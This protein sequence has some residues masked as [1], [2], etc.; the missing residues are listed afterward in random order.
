MKQLLKNIAPLYALNAKI[1]ARA[2]KK[3]YQRTCTYYKSQTLHQGIKYSEDKV[4]K[5]VLK[6]LEER[7]IRFASKPSGSVKIL[8]V[9]S[10]E[11]QDT[12]GFLQ[13]LEMFGRIHVFRK[14][15]GT[16]GHYFHGHGKVA[17]KRREENGKRLIEIVKS[18]RNEGGIDLILGQ[19]WGRTMPWE[20]LKEVQDMG[21]V[22]VNI[23]MDDRHSFYG[24]KYKVNRMGTLGLINGLDMVLTA[25]PEVCQWY[26][27]EGC[28]AIF[29]PEASNPDI[30]HP[31]EITK[32]HEV[33]FVG[34]NYGIRSRIVQAIQRRGISVKCFGTGWPNGKIATKNVPALFAAS[35]IVL[36]V[37][38]IGHCE[39]FYSLKLRDFDA[40]L[41]GSMYIT[42][43][44]PDLEQLFDVD[45]EIVRYQTPQQCA[46]KCAYY[47]A[48]EQ[49]REFIAQAGLKR[50]LH[51]HTW[52][53]RFDQMFRTIGLLE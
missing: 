9:G 40:T 20:A 1:K 16:Y 42:H 14:K 51:D 22:T 11:G 30:F 10:D 27:V 41:S 24:K 26:T 17:E 15:N 39:D 3:R 33:C 8:Y 7:G 29:W 48:H 12:S 21:I 50:S 52:K 23:C 32:K 53:S 25:A 37:G 5:E 28:P 36:G 18:I 6:R 13:S 2:Q 19:M 31:M 44:N 4:H 47:L 49:E 35:K 43:A 46:E 38:T 34:A 45:K